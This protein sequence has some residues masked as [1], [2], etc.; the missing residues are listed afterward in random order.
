MFSVKS[1][2]Q[3]DKLAA[4]I[5]RIEYMETMLQAGRNEIAELRKQ[6]E[7][8]ARQIARLQARK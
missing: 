1:K 3:D 6:N 8:Q 2:M 5:G 7:E 4:V